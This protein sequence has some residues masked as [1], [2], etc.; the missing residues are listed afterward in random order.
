MPCRKPLLLALA[1]VL[2]ACAAVAAAPKVLYEKA[3][4]YNRIVV[5]EDERGLRVLSFGN[6]VRQSVVKLG[7]PDHLELRY[8]RAMPAAVALV[9]EP[10]RV[11]IVG[12][13]GG[14]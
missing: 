9:E 4:P 2:T 10:R 6:G 12:L 3:S 11:L 8:S 5:T 14:T 13:G 7:D 1:A